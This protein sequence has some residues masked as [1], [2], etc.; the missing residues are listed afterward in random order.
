[1]SI[2][3]SQALWR[4]SQISV[5]QQNRGNSSVTSTGHGEWRY[6]WGKGQIKEMCLQIFLKGSNWNGWTDRQREV[7]P[8]RWGTTVKSSSTS[9]GLDPRDGQTINIVWSQWTGRNRCG[10]HGVKRN[11]L[12]FT[13]G[14]VGQQI[15]LKR[16]SK[17]YW[18]PMKGTKQWNTASKRRRF[19][20][21]AGQLILYTLKPCEVNVKFDIVPDRLAPI[22]GCRAV[23]VMGLVT[24]ATN[25][26]ESVAAV[27]ASLK[28]KDDYMKDYPE[29]SNSPVGMLEGAVSFQDDDSIA[30]TALPARML[31]IALRDPCNA[32]K[33]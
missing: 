10:K 4:D 19:C 23:Q 5:Q 29:V 1:M 24:M 3:K 6:L 30:P 25:R 21:Q 27:N 16:Y 7:V 26:F 15:D 22:L 32:Y 8:K 13:Q 28:S 11:R 31:P 2:I 17:P 33:A 14:F 9:I 20:H 18:Q 12:F